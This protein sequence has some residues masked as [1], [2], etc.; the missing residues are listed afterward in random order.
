MITLDLYILG[1]K[2]DLKEEVSVTIRDSIKQS[3]KIGSVFTSF[4]Q[5]F[6]LPA[7]KTNNKIFRH[8]YNVNI[9]EGFDSRRKHTAL[10]KLNGADYKK[11]YIKLNGVDEKDN[12]AISYRVQFFGELT[13]LKDQLGEDKLE[14]LLWLNRY[15]H[16][17]DIATVRAGFEDSLL[18][19]PGSG[20]AAGSDGQIKYPFIS[21]TRGFKYDTNGLYDVTVSSTPD[22][23]DRL[24][25]SDLK[26]AL[27][28]TEILSAIE[29]KYQLKFGGDFIQSKMFNQLFL[30]LH[31][32]KGNVKNGSEVDNLNF[33]ANLNDGT[34]ENELGFLSGDPDIRPFLTKSTFPFGDVIEYNVAFEVVTADPGTYQ[35]S[36]VAVP[37]NGG[38][39]LVSVLD[40]VTGTNTVNLTL[41]SEGSEFVQWDVGFYVYA[42]NTVSSVTPTVTVEYEKNNTVEFTSV[43]G[44]SSTSL[45]K[46]IVIT[47]NLPKM[48]IMDFLS[49]IFRLFNLVA[50]TQPINLMT[51]SY[52]IILQPLDSFYDSG[53]AIDITRY[54]DI[55]TSSVERVSPYNVLNFKYPKP[56]TFLAINANEINRNEFGNATFSTQDFGPAED[57][58]L[59]D[60]G[61][62][63][64]DVKFEKMQFERIVNGT[65][66]GLT[67][68]QWGWFVN[69]FSENNPEP[70]L[71]NPLLFF[72]VNRSASTDSIKW[73]DNTDSTAYNAPSNVDLDQEN[74]LNFSAE[75]DEYTLL[76]N[77][78]S[79]FANYYTRYVSGIYDR[80]ARRKVLTCYLPP[81]FILNYKLNDKIIVNAVAYNI[82]EIKINL[83][84]G[85]TKLDLLKITGRGEVFDIDTGPCYV[86]PGYVQSGYVSCFPRTK[87]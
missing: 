83:K 45:V 6:K 43:Y 23:G 31:R 76:I 38:T 56:K 48:R 81:R 57:S 69:D 39:P 47:S 30:W 70:E 11:G 78:N 74:T 37:N 28:I 13:S 50:Y 9:L 75:I 25:H 58:Y 22:L 24:A 7:S 65:T 8:Y 2:A 15:N 72:S 42:S 35:A 12:K 19:T 80:D 59:F 79:L 61:E 71:G 63:S 44:G 62:Y 84:D 4:S 87:I 67:Q 66:N 29:D 3:K 14:D 17:Y 26:P 49:Y 86:Q 51:D 52:E 18:L 10:I 85:K 1:I 41:A 46:E 53:S 21:H 73:S 60:G 27:K 68:L 82:E 33:Y 55:K 20:M 5:Q 64:V 40:N 54:V 32:E 77:E 16:T 34:G 36:I